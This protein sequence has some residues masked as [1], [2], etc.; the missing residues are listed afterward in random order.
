MAC[1]YSRQRYNCKDC[2]VLLFANISCRFVLNV[3][4]VVVL[5][6]VNMV[7]VQHVNTVVV[8]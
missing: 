7:G 8:L 5:L 4:T 3:K 1:E 6:S 2:G